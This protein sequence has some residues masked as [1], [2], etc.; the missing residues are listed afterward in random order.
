MACTFEL[1]SEDRGAASVLQWLRD[2][3]PDL[4]ARAAG[5]R[6]D[7]RTIDLTAPLPECDTIEITTFDDEDGREVF[8][9]TA[10]HV[11]A[12]AVQE[13]YPGTHLAIGP[14]IEDGFYYDFDADVTFG[15][16]DLVKIEAKMAE[17][18]KDDLPLQRREMPRAEAIDLFRAREERYKVELLAEMPDEMVTVYSQG[19]FADLCRG[20]HLPSNGRCLLERR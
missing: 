17:I 20:P 16:D 7:G 15:P 12:Q 4:A 6:A 9:H 8:R 5:A 13:I 11:M 14:A 2:R 1:K 19:D 10:S 18:V 3:D